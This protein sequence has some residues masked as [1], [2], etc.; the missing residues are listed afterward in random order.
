MRRVIAYYAV[1]GTLAFGAD[2]CAGLPASR[3]GYS[4]GTP[5]AASYRLA[6]KPAGPEFRINIRPL[7]FDWNSVGSPELIHAGD[8]EVARCKDGVQVQVLP[9]MA[10]QPIN[11]AAT[12]ETND[13]NFD[14]Y[15][16][17]SVLAEYGAKYQSS[18]WWIYDPKSGR[19]IQNDLTKQLHDLGSNG[20][21]FDPKKNEITYQLVWPDQ[22]GQPMYRYRLDNN[23]LT[24]VHKEEVEFVEPDCTLT[25]SDLVRGE[26]V[27]TRVVR[28][29]PTEEN[30]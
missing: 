20:V 14:G 16:D 30:R 23:R 13:V 4:L 28:F 19:F 17:F 29:K 24:L 8:I 21:D 26:W 2:V 1:C 27:E 11:F 5:S 7:L 6:V 18:W 3:S 12:F 10:Q 22:C 25:V 9:I 15:L